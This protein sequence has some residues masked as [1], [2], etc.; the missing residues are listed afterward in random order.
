MASSS[1]KAQTCVRQS[2][3]SSGEDQMPHHRRAVTR[4]QFIQATGAGSLAIAGA[5]SG[6]PS[7]AQAAKPNI[8][9]IMADDLG[10]ADVRCYRQRDYTT[11][12]VEPPAVHGV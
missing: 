4:R 11:P 9:F 5:G 2:Q 3:K 1:R 7:R 8:V 10:Y 6:R 12:N